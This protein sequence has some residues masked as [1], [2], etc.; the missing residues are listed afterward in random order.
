MK[1]YFLQLIIG[2]FLLP[3]ALLGQ[4]TIDLTSYSGFV[5]ARDLQSDIVQ[6]PL[7]RQAMLKNEKPGVFKNVTYQLADNVRVLSPEQKSQ[8]QIKGDGILDRSAL[9]ILTLR[10]FM[11]IAQEDLLFRHSPWMIVI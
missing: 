1:R 6:H 10:Q 4:Q 11:L 2:L 3:A 5:T 9:L 7:A 8:L